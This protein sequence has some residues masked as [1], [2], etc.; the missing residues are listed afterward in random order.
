MMHMHHGTDL[1]FEVHSNL[2]EMQAARHDQQ[3]QQA[4]LQLL[5]YSPAAAGQSEDLH[6]LN[7]HTNK[8]G[9]RCTNAHANKQGRGRSEGLH[10]Q[11]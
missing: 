1:A 9:V 3:R 7:A 6:R 2:I 5:L 4:A 11:S 10:G 8:Q